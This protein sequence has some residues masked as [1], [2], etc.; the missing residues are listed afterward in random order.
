[1]SNYL[2]SLLF[3]SIPPLMGTKQTPLFNKAWQ[4][5]CGELCKFAS[6][7]EKF[8]DIKNRKTDLKKGSWR[9]IQN[10]KTMGKG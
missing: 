10:S 7:M 6:P 4:T 1:M 5:F 2:L 8:W 3:F 9:T